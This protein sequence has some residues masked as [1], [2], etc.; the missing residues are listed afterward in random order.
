MSSTLEAAA[1]EECL[2]LRRAYAA[3]HG[4][5]M[6]KAAETA[7]D[8]GVKFRPFQAIGVVMRA[9]DRDRVFLVG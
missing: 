3:K 9:M 8:I 6:G 1:V 7:D 2:F 4:I 5:A